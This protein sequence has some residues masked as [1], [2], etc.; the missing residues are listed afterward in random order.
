M[1]TPPPTEKQ[2]HPDWWTLGIYIFE[3][4]HGVTPFRGLDHEMTLVN[5]VAR[6][7]E[8]LPEGA[9]RAGSRQGPDIAAAGEG[10]GSVAGVGDGGVGNTAPS[11]L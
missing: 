5:I 7:L 4:F 1:E 9:K 2:Q 6:A 8:F 10:P 11:V 3:L